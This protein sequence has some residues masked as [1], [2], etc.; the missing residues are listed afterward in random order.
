MPYHKEERVSLLSSTA[1]HV[2]FR[3]FYNLAGLGLMVMSLRLMIENIIKYGW[4]LKWPTTQMV[5]WERTWP[6]LIAL[7]AVV[8]LGP[9]ISYT[10]ESF[11]YQQKI[12]YKTTQR[13]HVIS[14][15]TMFL[16][17]MLTIHFSQSTLSMHIY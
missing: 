11:A 9:P 13:L 3:G 15:L 17:P 7:A 5:V 14:L 12:S 1:S 8:L 10:I 4:R 16:A 6:A 2:N